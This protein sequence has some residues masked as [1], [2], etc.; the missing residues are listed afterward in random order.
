MNHF[1]I[2]VI[3]LEGSPDKA[4]DVME[5]QASV[6]GDSISFAKLNPEE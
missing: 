1:W 3:R 4:I 2:H 5:I 6:P